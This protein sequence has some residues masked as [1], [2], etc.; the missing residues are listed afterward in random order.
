[1]LRASFNSAASIRAATTCWSRRRFAESDCNLS[2]PLVQH[3]HL[4]C[5]RDVRTRQRRADQC[6]HA[7]GQQYLSRLL[8]FKDLISFLRHSSENRGTQSRE[9]LF[10]SIKRKL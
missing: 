3:L 5:R 10:R 6:Y 2:C 8:I 1:M 7:V 9:S 4:E